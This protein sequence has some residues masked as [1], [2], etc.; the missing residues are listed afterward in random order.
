MLLSERNEV[1]DA[2]KHILEGYD[3]LEYDEGRSQGKKYLHVEV[4]DQTA[5]RSED[6][7]HQI[8]SALR[9][10]TGLRFMSPPIAG[11]GHVDGNWTFFRIREL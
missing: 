3:F 4:T 9:H 5:D 11:T 7:I 10:A 2:L 8:C 6:V 1:V